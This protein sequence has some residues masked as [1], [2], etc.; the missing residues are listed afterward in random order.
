MVERLPRFT[1]AKAKTTQRPKRASL[2]AGCCGRRENAVGGTI[3]VAKCEARRE[4][5]FDDELAVVQ[6]QVMSAAQGDEI[7]GVMRAP[8]SARLQMMNI[9][10][11]RVGAPWHLATVMVAPQHRAPHGGRDIL[12][13]VR[14]AR[15]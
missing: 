1:F 3:G 2:D 15:F 7:R 11:T 6:C 14:V 5:P 10:P 12:R 8:V 9:D 13:R 4:R